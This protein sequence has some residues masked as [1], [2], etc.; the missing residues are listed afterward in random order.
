MPAIGFAGSGRTAD[1]GAAAARG[2]QHQDRPPTSSRARLTGGRTARPRRPG[3][4][5]GLRSRW[6][7]RTA[8]VWRSRRPPGCRSP[9]SRRRGGPPRSRRTRRRS[10]SAPRPGVDR[11][12]REAVRAH[13]V[14]R[15][16]RRGLAAWVWPRSSHSACSCAF[17]K[18]RKSAG[19]PG[20][21]SAR[22]GS[23]AF[24]SVPWYSISVPAR[25]PPVSRWPARAPARCRTSSRE[26]GQEQQAARRSR[27]SPQLRRAGAA[28]PD[29][30]V[31][32]AVDDPG[33]HQPLGGQVRDPEA[34]PVGRKTMSPSSWGPSTEPHRRLGG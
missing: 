27:P 21:R 26:G 13:R 25:P 34:T 29:P 10:R 12:H 2:R 14:D 6:G 32:A 22:S 16:Q 17:T 1:A 23:T 20:S 8:P 7:C 5:R 4:T 33:L 31:D 15:D 3:S 24:D 28:T 18:A 30:P 11:A 9:L 19:A